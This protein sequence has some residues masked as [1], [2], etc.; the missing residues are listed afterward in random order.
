[1]WFSRLTFLEGIDLSVI[2][3]VSSSHLNPS[4]DQAHTLYV[5]IGASLFVTFTTTIVS[6]VL[7]AYRIHTLQGSRK[8]F[9]H[10]LEILVQSAAAYSVAEVAYAIVL[11][12]HFPINRHHIESWLAAYDYLGPFYFFIAVCISDHLLFYLTFYVN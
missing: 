9:K 6:T 8:R 5:L 11:V 12:V 3:I 7:I 4:Q 2:A 1:M 10:I